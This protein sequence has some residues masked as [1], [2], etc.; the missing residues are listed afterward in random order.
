MT[1]VEKLWWAQQLR[2]KPLYV[3]KLFYKLVD[4]QTFWSIMSVYAL[5][6][7]FEDGL[8]R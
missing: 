5:V 3:L 2:N 1:D 7:E 4:E 6:R 8:S